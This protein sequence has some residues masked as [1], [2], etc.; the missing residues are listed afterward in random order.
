MSVILDFLIDFVFPKFCVVCGLEGSFLCSRCKK[1]LP[2]A[3]QVCPLCTRPSIYGLTHDYCR[4][5]WGMEGLMAIFDYKDLNVRRII[6]AVKFGFNRELVRIVLSGWKAPKKW[7]SLVLIPVPLHRYRKNWRGFNQAELV[8]SEVARG[9][10]PIV[11][12]LMRTKVT[13][14]QARTVSRSVRREN[15]KGAF[16]MTRAGL[17]LR[18][19]KVILVDDV[20]TS[21]ATMS[22]CAKVLRQAGIKEVWGFVLAR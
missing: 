7:K 15:M 14:Q 3:L 4:Q 13:N 19:K 20:F 10:S 18:G 12:A 16:E 6:E 21:G 8:A 5:K 22:E 1:K 11:E 17:G 9:R 2:M